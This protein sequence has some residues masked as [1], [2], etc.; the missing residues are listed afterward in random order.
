[1]LAW[2]AQLATTVMTMRI[3]LVEICFFPY[4][5]TV[6]VR[7][8]VEPRVMVR[9]VALSAGENIGNL[10]QHINKSIPTHD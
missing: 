3:L 6:V 8:R 5:L 4:G 10:W 9:A 7:V 2:I 1:M